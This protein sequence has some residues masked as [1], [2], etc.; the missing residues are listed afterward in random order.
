MEKADVLEKTAPDDV[1]GVLSRCKER[2]GTVILMT[3]RKTKKAWTTLSTACL[4]LVLMG[5]G[6]F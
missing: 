5:G 4:A 6:L 1:G 2:K 3:T